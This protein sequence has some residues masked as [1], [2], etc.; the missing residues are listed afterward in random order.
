MPPCGH[1]SWST[2]RRRSDRRRGPHVTVDRPPPGRK[3]PIINRDSIRSG[4]FADF[5]AEGAALGLLRLLTD[6]ERQAS[7]MRAMSQAAP[8]QDVWVF[9]YGSL[10]W[11]PAFHFTE[12]RLGHVYG[13]HRSF[14]M[15]TPL[16]R[17]SP[18]NP[19]LMLA[20]D[21]GGSCRGVAFRIAARQ[22]DEELDIVWGREMITG[23]YYP[24]WVTVRTESGTVRAI[25]FVMNHKN[26]RYAGRLPQETIIRHLATAGG[27]LGT[28]FEYLENTANHLDE[29]GIEDGPMHVL[30]KRVCDYRAREQSS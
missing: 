29:L 21:N 16:G 5:V 14:C 30:L 12:R 25:T 15:W 20:L 8:G 17:G 24:R 19:G 9:G 2:A 10:M 6:E 26:E 4:A 22:V 11:N 7:R 1:G 13:F 18:E 28:A 27:K 23:S 3:Q